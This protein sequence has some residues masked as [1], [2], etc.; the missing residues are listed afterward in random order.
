VVSRETSKLAEQSKLNVMP[1]MCISLFHRSQIGLKV[2][3]E[4]LNI[5]CYC[6][7][8]RLSASD[9]MRLIQGRGMLCAGLAHMFRNITQDIIHEDNELTM[10]DKTSKD[11]DNWTAANRLYASAKR[12]SHYCQRGSPFEKGSRRS[13]TQR[14]Q[15]VRARRMQKAGWKLGPRV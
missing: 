4:I 3:Y 11:S 15:D 13:D 1:V 8:R 6:N 5:H 10:R 7:D 2:F 12:V 9:Y 14:R